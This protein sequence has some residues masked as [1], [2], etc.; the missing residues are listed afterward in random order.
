MLELLHDEASR[1]WA[2]ASSGRGTAGKSSRSEGKEVFFRRS[3]VRDDAAAFGLAQ[4]RFLREGEEERSSHRRVSKA[5][6]GKSHKT[7]LPCK[8]A[9]VAL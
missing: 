6:T 9:S 1:N 4:Q 5:K 2:R 8:R 3:Q 7:S